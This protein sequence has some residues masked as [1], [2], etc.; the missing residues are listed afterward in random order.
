MHP[1]AP[2]VVSNY[3]RKYIDRFYYHTIHIVPIQLYT[4]TRFY[5]TGIKIVLGIQFNNNFT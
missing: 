4:F 1:N 5:S 2:L 3:H